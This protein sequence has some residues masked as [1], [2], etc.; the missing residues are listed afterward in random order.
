MKNSADER[1]RSFFTC[2]LFLPITYYS[3]LITSLFSLPALVLKSIPVDFHIRLPLFVANRT[4]SSS[5]FVCAHIG[6]DSEQVVK[7][8]A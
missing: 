6:G 5:H 8:F 3:L 1:P 7:L 2:L 4:D